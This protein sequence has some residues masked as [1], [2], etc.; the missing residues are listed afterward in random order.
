MPLLLLPGMLGNGALWDG[1]AP[2]LATQASVQIGRIDLD[3]TVAEMA[4]SV[5]AAAPARFAVA[6][7]SLGGIVALE[8][9][10]RAPR[11]VLRLALL[12]TS[13]RPPSPAQLE[14]WSSLRERT[15]AGAFGT[16][17][18]E[19]AIAD[20][21]AA[22]REVASLTTRVEGMARRIGASAFLRQLAAQEARP[23]LRPM[24]SHVR[25]PTLVLSGSEDEV[26]PDN[27][28]AEIAAG[29]STAEHVTIGGAGHMTPLEAPSAVAEQ[30]LEWLRR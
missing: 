15:E 27:L 28:Q 4:D 6:G 17:V 3:D 1:V 22:A 26:C 29:V 16:V 23:D 5:L 24:L 2:L 10:R 19:F 18:T 7:H 8:L 25:V 13:A 21:P 14:A 30:M 9:T 11:R 12:K 20:L